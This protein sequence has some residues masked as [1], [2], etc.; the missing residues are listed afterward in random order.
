MYTCVPV[1]IWTLFSLSC[2][3]PF[4]ST[5]FFLE[6]AATESLAVSCLNGAI[7]KFLIFDTGDFMDEHKLPSADLYML[8]QIIHDWRPD[9]VDFLLDKV[10]KALLPGSSSVLSFFLI[11]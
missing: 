5:Q 11:D 2:S 1:N 7:Y 10:Y 6:F 9:Q 8:S 4:L 3:A